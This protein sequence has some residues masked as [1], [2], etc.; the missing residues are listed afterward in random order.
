MHNVAYFYQSY[1]E[2]SGHLRLGR[3]TCG[4]AA[5][6]SEHLF[7]SAHVW[8]LGSLVSIFLFGNQEC[9]FDPGVLAGNIMTDFGVFHEGYDPTIVNRQTSDSIILQES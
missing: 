9:G 4:S 7:R 5:K 2:N 8:S 6:T 3:N 1:F